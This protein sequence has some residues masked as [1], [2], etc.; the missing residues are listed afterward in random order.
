MLAAAVVVLV[1]VCFLCLFQ[2]VELVAFTVY[3]ISVLVSISF[4]FFT[5]K[6]LCCAPASMSKV[7]VGVLGVFF[8]FL[9]KLQNKD[10]W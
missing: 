6:C 9:V 2:I 3:L 4:F 5:S 1:W 10:L 8:V 7:L